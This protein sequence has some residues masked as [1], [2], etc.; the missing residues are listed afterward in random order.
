MKKVI[1]LA[2]AVVLGVASINQAAIITLGN[3]GGDTLGQSSFAAGTHWSNGLAPSAGNDYVVGIS[4]LRT[5][6][7][8]NSY[9]F[10][11][12]SLSING[13]AGDFGYKG[14]GNTG[15]IT[16]N[17]LILNGG[18]IRQIQGATDVF[19]LAGNLSVVA[20]SQLYAK[21]GPIEVSSVIS[22]S[23]TLTNPG[24]DGA[25]RTLHILSPA[26]TFTGNLV[27][28][29]RLRLADDAVLNFVIGAS[30][31]NNSV[32]GN[33]AEN[34][35]E[36]DFVFNLSGAGTT[37]G[38]SWS[39]VSAA[40]KSYGTTFNVVGFSEASDVWSKSVAGVGVY[41]FSEASGTL[42]LVVPEPTSLSVLALSGLMLRRRSR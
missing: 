16:V 9:T 31:V 10:A 42:S 2:G 20:D 36:G 6:A 40:N 18:L 37:N 8:G 17:N 23:A 7:D 32:S 14:V 39:V 4:L 15:V 28:N 25:G 19:K 11:G 13:P 33:G 26:N 22:G 1:A 5:P 41:S 27:N 24:S 21:Q 3:P 38:D 34:V 29:G 12:D 35:F 30:G